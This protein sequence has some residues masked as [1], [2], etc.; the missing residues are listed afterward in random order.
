MR[1]ERVRSKHGFKGLGKFFLGCFVGFLV[2]IL[3]VVGLVYWAYT[4]INVRRV[5]KWTKSNI[6]SNKK[7]EE[8]TL[9]KVVSISKGILQNSKDGYTIAKFEDDFNITLFDESNAPF[10]M[11]LSIIKNA[12]FKDLANAFN[13]TIET[14]TFNNVLKFLNVE[15]ENIGIVNTALEK[16]STYYIYNGKLFSNPEYTIE[17]DFKYTIEEGVVKF[18]NGAHTITSNTINPRL[19]DL[20]LNVAIT[21][22]SNTTRS[23]NISEI[24]GYKY[25]NVTKK[26]YK[27]CVDGVYSDEIKGFMS[28]IAGYS[29]DDLSSQSIIN[30]FKVY[31]VL[32]YYY[33]QADQNYYTS[34][35][36]EPN[37]KVAGVINAI[38]GQTVG[39]LSKSETYNNLHLYQVMGYDYEDGKYLYKDG[40]EVKGVMSLLVDS[41]VSALPEKVDEII[42]ENTIYDLVEEGVIVLEAGVVMDEDTKAF[43]ERYTIPAL[44]KFLSDNIE[45]LED[46]SQTN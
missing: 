8:L 36:F 23:L 5:E 39:D 7:L 6:T 40:T 15:S 34:A 29:I 17:V 25:D 26:Y 11:D 20:P 33:N 21:K 30:E 13:E 28:A 14:I 27:V 38:A 3:S 22:L 35:D 32:G 16:T 31:E 2:A 9:K 1:R 42:N 10:G 18:A 41:S 12:Q 43:F 46:L 37:T 4:S 19:M 24:L 45:V 44:I